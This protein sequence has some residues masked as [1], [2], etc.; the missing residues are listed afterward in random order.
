MTQQERTYTEIIAKV[1]NNM[2]LPYDVVDRTYR[3][4]W[5]FVRSSITELPL[6]DDLTEEEFRK[7]RTN[8]NIPSLGKLVCTYDK[9]QRVKQRYKYIKH[10]KENDKHQED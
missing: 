5:L 6:K 1:A 3:A 2:K 8:V 9:Y 10:L 7:L 4:F